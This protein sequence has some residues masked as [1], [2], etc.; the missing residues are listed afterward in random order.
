LDAAT[1]VSGLTNAL[2]KPPVSG[3]SPVS[4]RYP[5]YKFFVWRPYK[6]FILPSHAKLHSGVKDKL[7]QGHLL[8]VAGAAHV[9]RNQMASCF[10]F[11]CK[12]EYVCGH[13]S[14]PIVKAEPEKNKFC[15][16]A[17]TI[18]PGCMTSYDAKR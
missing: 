13:Q 16:I 10:P 3:T 8:T 2:A 1:A 15:R 14:N 6:T 11:N 9:G 5:G 7:P 18:S 12:H 4:G 17:Q